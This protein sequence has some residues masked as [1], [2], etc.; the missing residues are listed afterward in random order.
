MKRLTDKHESLYSIEKL[1]AWAHMLDIGKHDSYETPPDLPYFRGKAA[2][3]GVLSPE[4][5]AASSPG[6]SSSSSSDA[7][8]GPSGTGV[9]PGKR[10]NMRTQLLSQMEQ[11]HCLLEKVASQSSSMTSFKPPY[12]QISIVTRSISDLTY[13]PN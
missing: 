10:I 13:I 4:S 5:A 1:N 11:W 7:G 9:S 3:K 6:A 2:K 8:A 12:L